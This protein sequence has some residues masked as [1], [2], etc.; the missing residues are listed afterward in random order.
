MVLVPLQHL[1]QNV[2]LVMLLFKVL[3]Q[4]K[5]L[6]PNALQVHILPI[7]TLQKELRQIDLV[8]LVIP[9]MDYPHLLDPMLL[10]I[11]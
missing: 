8:L 7:S 5:V 3:M 1:Q 11:V 2:L 4:Q 6:V 9:L 10:V